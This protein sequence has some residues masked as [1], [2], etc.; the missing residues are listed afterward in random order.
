MIYFLDSPENDYLSPIDAR[1]LSSPTESNHSKSSL[2]SDPYYH[3]LE[4]GENA[5]YESAD[6]VKDG[7]TKLNNMGRN[8]SDRS[9]NRYAA[10]DDDKWVAKENSIYEPLTL[11]RSET[12]PTKDFEN[13]KIGAL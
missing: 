10:L 1:T 11:A 6:D 3:M 7:L 13:E 5:T 4:T 8:P 12:T 9:E 2:H